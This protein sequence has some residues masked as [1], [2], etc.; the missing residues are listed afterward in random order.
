M[1]SQNIASATT[2]PTMDTAGD[3]AASSNREDVM[4]ALNLFSGGLKGFDSLLG[5]FSTSQAYKGSAQ[6]LEDY[7]DYRAQVAVNSASLKED[8]IRSKGAKEKGTFVAT[9]GKRGLA[10]TGSILDVYADRASSLELEAIMARVEGAQTA[11][12]LKYQGA[13]EAYALNRKAGAAQGQS[14]IDT[15]SAAVG[16]ATNAVKIAG[17]FG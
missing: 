16:T 1:G 10:M 14:L 4:K 3:P 15:A 8:I 6:A 9:I 12:T 11:R 17:M 2:A 13:A 5:G 7:Y